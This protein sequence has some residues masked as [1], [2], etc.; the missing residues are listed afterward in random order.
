ADQVIY[1]YTEGM[2][3]PM[4]HFG[5]YRRQPLAVLVRDASLR[6]AEPG[7]YRTKAKLTGRGAYDVAFLLDSPRFFH[8]FELTVAENP[9]SKRA[10]AAIQVEPL[11][12]GDVLPVSQEVPLRFK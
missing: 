8:C 2:A 11:L 10:Q 4:G 12:K 5:N 7:V 3:A 9:Q 1:Y 6:E